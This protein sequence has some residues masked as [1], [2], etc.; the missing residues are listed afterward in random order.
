M[1]DLLDG[2]TIG[3]LFRELARVERKIR[4]CDPLFVAVGSQDALSPELIEL[5]AREQQ[6]CDELARRRAGLRVELT[7]RLQA[8]QVPLAS[9]VPDASYARR[10]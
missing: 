7:A 2:A 10:E 3:E 6:I 8:M 1:I 9:T 4:D 5:A